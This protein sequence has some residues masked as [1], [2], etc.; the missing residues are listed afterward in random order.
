MAKS[1]ITQPTGIT[2]EFLQKLNS[3]YSSTELRSVQTK[4]TSTAREVRKLGS[5]GPMGSGLSGRISEQ[6]SY[7]QRQLLLDAA[8]LIESVNNH[9][10]HAKEKRVRDEKATKRRQDARN[11]RAKQLIAAKFPLLHETVEQQ[12]EVLKDALVF[13][14]AG[15]H[16]G[17]CDPIKYN[18]EWM[19][20]LDD[21]HKAG[22]WTTPLGYLKSHIVSARS[23]LIQSLSSDIA[24]D[25]GS[26]VEE[27]LNVLKQKVADCLARAPLT[28]AEETTLLHWKSALTLNAWGEV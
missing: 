6:L 11:A 15:V 14:R 24:Y 3:R 22:S 17:F 10:E 4:F 21:A 9:I 18:Q 23:E 16:I 20:C 8:T 7:E 1:P 19:K 2:P 12:L 5:G 25:D 13:N 28:A 26:D 27:R